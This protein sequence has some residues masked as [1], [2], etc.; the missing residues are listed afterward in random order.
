MADSIYSAAN[1]VYCNSH[2]DIAHKQ[3]YGTNC[4]G[5]ESFNIDSATSSGLNPTENTT[6]TARQAQIIIE[7]D[8]AQEPGKIVARYKMCG[9]EPTSTSGFPVGNFGT[10]C[11][12]GKQNIENFKII[13]AEGAGVPTVRVMYFE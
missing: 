4:C 2:D 5:G 8:D 6:K 3:V 13:A 10:I 11:V 12:G 7:K 9:A 1:G